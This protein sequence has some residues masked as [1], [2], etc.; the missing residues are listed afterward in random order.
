MTKHTKDT[1]DFFSPAS[2]YRR[3]FPVQDNQIHTWMISIQSDAVFFCDEFTT[4]YL[5]IKTKGSAAEL[6]P[7]L[8]WEIELLESLPSII[9]SA[10]EHGVDLIVEKRVSKNSD[11][12]S[13]ADTN[14]VIDLMNQTKYNAVLKA[15]KNNLGLLEVIN[16][17]SGLGALDKN[18]NGELDFDELFE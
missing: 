6:T 13:Y 8:R 4:T 17:M 12:A 3:T 18:G 1:K 11:Y 16:A 2:Y 15:E 10:K 7:Y 5:T 9:S 14:G